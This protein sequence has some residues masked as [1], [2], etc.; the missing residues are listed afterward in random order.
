MKFRQEPYVVIR[1]GVT[2]GDDTWIK[3]FTCIY[4]G[5]KIGRSCKIRAQCVICENAVIGNHVE[6]G[7]GVKLMDHYKMCAFT[8]QDDIVKAP[9]IGHGCRVGS[10]T[11]LYAGCFIGNNT[12]LLPNSIVREDQILSGGVWGMKNGKLVRLR[13]LNA[14]EMI[15]V[16]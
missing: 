4:S 16:A 9:R 15:A 3:E 8:G 1:D 5:A 7:V 14:E 12:I 10:D 2:I 6:F 13:D 11:Q